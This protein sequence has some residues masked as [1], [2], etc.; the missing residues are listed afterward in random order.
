MFCNL[1]TCSNKRRSS[2]LICVAPWNEWL[3]LFIHT[4]W[5][6]FYPLYLWE[7][8]YGAH[9]FYWMGRFWL[10][11]STTVQTQKRRKRKRSLWVPKVERGGFVCLRKS[12]WNEFERF[13][14]H[15]YVF[16]TGTSLRLAI[17]CFPNYITVHAA[18]KYSLTVEF[19]WR[20]SEVFVVRMSLWVLW[21]E[22]SN[23]PNWFLTIRIVTVKETTGTTR[24]THEETQLWSLSPLL[25]HLWII[26]TTPVFGFW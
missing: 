19:L 5:P 24:P 12:S 2:T 13:Q 9:K 4:R 17:T 14:L 7:N 3:D 21:S 8:I 15:F 10:G 18:I 11:P 22:L 1:V 6:V 26:Q 23:T 16:R 20:W 25:C